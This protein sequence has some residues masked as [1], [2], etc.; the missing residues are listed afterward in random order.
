MSETLALLGKTISFRPY[1]F[2]FLAVYL[3]AA[4]FKLGVKKTALF[5]LTAWA[6]AY[7]AEFS[8][9]R[10]GI[11]F[12]LY[13]YIPSTLDKELWVFGVPFMDSL[14]FAFLAYAS[15]TT[16]RV[17]VSPHDGRGLKL[18]FTDEPAR[19]RLPVVLMGALMFML[20]DVVIDPLSLRGDR[21]FLGKIY[22]YPE[23]GVYFG[24]TIANFAGWFAVGLA[25][26]TIWGWLDKKFKD[27]GRGFGGLDLVGP[28]L[29][30]IVLIFNLGMTF[31]IGELNI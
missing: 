29:Y 12:G 11:P 14:S 28:A 9:V 26:L 10:T 16:A 24:V 30:F 4:S 8:S 31:Y 25:T 21:W 20:I 22:Y 6:I 7:A 23:P 17:L 1:V 2:A 5:T 19:F 3:V 18:M 27:A 15:W 13:H